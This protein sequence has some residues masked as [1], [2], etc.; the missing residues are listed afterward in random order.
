MGKD[1]GT[2]HVRV[3]LKDG[4]GF[5]MKWNT[6]GRY[7]HGSH[8]CH[9]LH[10]QWIT[11]TYENEEDL[12]EGVAYMFLE[13]NFNCAENIEDFLADAHQ[14]DRPNNGCHDCSDAKFTSITVIRPDRSEI[15]VAIP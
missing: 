15:E 8:S 6:G 3:I 10:A 5:I 2:Y 9:P 11:P 13:G 7:T 12:V 4:R 1:L 14:V